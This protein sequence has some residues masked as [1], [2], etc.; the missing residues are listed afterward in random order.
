MFLTVIH[1]TN[2]TKLNSL[3]FHFL[4]YFIGYNMKQVHHSSLIPGKKYLIDCF[5]PF[6][7]KPFSKKYATF[8]RRDSSCTCHFTNIYVRERGMWIPSTSFLLSIRD[9]SGIDYSR[10][11]YYEKVDDSI[12]LRVDSS[13]MKT[14]TILRPLLMENMLSNIDPYMSEIVSS[15]FLGSTT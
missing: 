9:T 7:T 5:K 6:E 8:H 2:Y 12:K 4:L 3:R 15:Q 14:D 10:Y 13:D 11:T 1:W